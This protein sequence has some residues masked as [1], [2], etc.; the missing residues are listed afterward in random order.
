MRIKKDINPVGT[1]QLVRLQNGGPYTWHKFKVIAVTGA[2]SNTPSP[3]GP[4]VYMEV[5]E[6]KQDW[7]QQYITLP[8]SAFDQRV[9]A[10]SKDDLF[11]EQTKTHQG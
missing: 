8:L 2:S 9:I 4:T 3:D 11:W 6:R 10:E 7:M 1:I 5:A